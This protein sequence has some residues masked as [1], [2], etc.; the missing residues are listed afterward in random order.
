MCD[1]TY[2]LTVLLFACY[3]YTFLLSLHLLKIYCFDKKNSHSLQRK[4]KILL[5]L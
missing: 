2:A 1:V 4:L 3:M 5:D